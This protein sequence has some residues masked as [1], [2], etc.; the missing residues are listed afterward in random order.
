MSRLLAN[1]K[2][3]K[4]LEAGRAPVHELHAALALDGG[5]GG[6][7]ILGHHVAPV[8]HAAG[9]VLAVPGRGEYLRTDQKI[10]TIK[11]HKKRYLGSH[12]TMELAGSKQALVISAT[13]KD[14][15]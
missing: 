7:D 9:H 8:E 12:F 10:E 3:L 15:W 5:D 11:D 2:D 14:S 13:L 4:Y 1:I 6:V